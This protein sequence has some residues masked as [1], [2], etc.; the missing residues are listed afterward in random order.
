IP[1]DDDDDDRGDDDIREDALIEEPAAVPL[2]ILF[3]IDNSAGMADA[4]RVLA[5]ELDGFVDRLAGGQPR[6]VQVMFT[7]TDIGHP[8][9]TDFQ[10]HDY[11]PAMG[12]PI[13][14]G[15]HERIDRFTGLGSDPER[16]EDACTSVCPVD[17]VPM[18]PFVAFDTGTWTNNVVPDRQERADV[19][20]ALACLLPQGIDGCGYEAPL[21]AM[22]QAL[23]PSE[24]WNS[25]ERPFMRDGADLAVVIVS[26]EA[27]CST[28]D[29]AAIYDEQY[30][31]ENPHSA[32][33]TPSSAMCWNMGASCVGP[34][35]SGTYSGCV[36]ADGPLHPVQ[37]YRDV[38]A[39]R[40]E[41][42]KRVSMLALTGVPRVSLWSN[43]APWTPVAGGLDGLIY[44]NWLL[45][46]LFDD[47]IK[48]GE[49]TEDMTWEF[50][51]A[52]GCTVHSGDLVG[53]RALPSPRIFD[54]CASLDEGDELNCC[55]ASL[56]GDYDDALRC[57]VG[58]SEP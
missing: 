32:G 22:A 24:P 56:C 43:E 7:T 3:V 11:E 30:W 8:M 37:R 35:P 54:T 46:D 21:E 19:V 5:E 52:P 58:V 17:V 2:D 51:I 57:L 40:R 44:R 39:A 4:Q 47:E 15:C 23:G 53:T 1:T 28:S 14:T 48:S 25:G 45:A 6:S 26:N 10:P 13:A 49:N 27:D 36:S 34:D 33:P 42:G 20:A 16:R 41:R 12:A 50:G 31:N 18:D 9:C 29:Y 38:L 55:V